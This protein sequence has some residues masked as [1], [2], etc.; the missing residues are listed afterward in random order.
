MPDP[1]GDISGLISKKTSKPK[2]K[3][4]SRIEVLEGRVATLESALK[5][6]LSELTALRADVERLKTSRTA[7]ETQFFLVA[8]PSETAKPP[9]EPPPKENT[10]TPTQ[11]SAKVD[12]KPPAT[13][14]QTKPPP[15]PKKSKSPRS[16]PWDDPEIRK[17]LEACRP[18]ILELIE[19][20]KEITKAGCAEKLGIDASLAGRTLSYMM[21]QT[22][23]V[24]MI[25]PPKTPEDPDP[26][27]RFRLIT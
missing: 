22:N 7:A 14:T 15:P 2:P 21:T 9:K 1:I 24:R 27:K 18:R 12:A 8:R 23:D 6:V 16:G 17:E 3:P 4:P 19:T 26:K 13:E 20:E 10:A 25:S 5:T 11:P